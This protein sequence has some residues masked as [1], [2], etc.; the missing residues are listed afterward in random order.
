VRHA[1]ERAPNSD[2]GVSETVTESAPNLVE[3]NI[4]TG[5]RARGASDL[6]EVETPSC[7][8]SD[9]GLAAA[10]APLDPLTVKNAFKQKYGLETY[11]THFAKVRIKD[12]TAIFTSVHTAK[13]FDRFHAFLK[14][15]GVRSM[16][17]DDDPRW[18][19]EIS[20]SRIASSST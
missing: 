15:Q 14:R 8:L 13:K 19:L 5:A 1:I 20:E 10:T 11:R 9:E 4:N 7:S 17:A 18:R 12:R 16:I 2:N 6:S 3:G